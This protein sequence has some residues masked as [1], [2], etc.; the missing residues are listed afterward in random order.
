MPIPKSFL[1]VHVTII[2]IVNVKSLMA[3][4][5]ATI[6]MLAVVIP[7]TGAMASMSTEKGTKD[8]EVGD[9]ALMAKVGTS[10]DL[11]ITN[12]GD[13]VQLYI[14]DADAVTLSS[15]QI[16]FGESFRMTVSSGFFN[17]T[18]FSSDSIASNNG[19]YMTIHNGQW[20]YYDSGSPKSAK[21]VKELKDTVKEVKEPAKAAVPNM[22]GTYKSVFYPDDA[23]KWLYTSAPVNVDSGV[24][25]YTLGARM[26][27]SGTLSNMAVT[28]SPTGMPAASVT[29]EYTASG[30]TNS[31]TGV[32]V[33]VGTDEPFEI[34]DGFLV[35]LAYSDGEK[36]GMTGT[37]VSLIPVVLIVGVIIAAVSM[38]ILRR[39]E[40][41]L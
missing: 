12:T 31:L 24:T 25:F 26:V 2:M 14:G 5:M 22:Q 41:V 9:G 28:R 37:L 3:V 35:P 11:M 32:L 23:G 17:L 15:G 10:A 39:Q 7:I 20:A 33:T 34:T 30:D 16:V 6:L 18:D 1:S 8:N 29:C 36:M 4:L 19:S 21:E 13:A 27:L 40:D 38:M